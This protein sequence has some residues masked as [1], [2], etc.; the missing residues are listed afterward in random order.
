MSNGKTTLTIRSGSIDS[1]DW[2][3]TTSHGGKDYVYRFDGPTG[4][5]DNDHKGKGK[6]KSV[7]GFPPGNHAPKDYEV[8]LLDEDDKHRFEIDH[9]DV[10]YG[11]SQF[12]GAKVSKSKAKLDNANK[13]YQQAF[14]CI[15]V[16]DTANN[17]LID[18]DP[19]ISNDP[20]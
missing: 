6:F 20:R 16:K 10:L 1:D 7:L 5:K 17:E 19:M 11:G 9:V 3:N 12:K 8:E 14:Y 18:C 2:Q 13:R 4:D 15:V